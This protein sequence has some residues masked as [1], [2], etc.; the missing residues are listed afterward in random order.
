[1]RIKLIFV[2]LFFVYKVNCQILIYVDDS[3]EIE[4]YFENIFNVKKSNHI[5]LPYMVFKE[6][7]PDGDYFFFNMTR[8]NA[9]SKKNIMD[10]VIMDGH[11]K[12]NKREGRFNSYQTLK[13]NKII[14]NTYNYKDG[15]LEGYYY[16][17]NTQFKLSEGYYA[18]GKRNGFFIF[19]SMDT[20]K[21]KS[22][23]LFVDD[24]LIYQQKYVN[25][26][27]IPLEKY[28]E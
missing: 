4:K 5:D 9:R 19:H 22:I 2:F 25:N 15:I 6:N 7:L 8:K 16:C 20:G 11:Y 17:S 12:N 18:N 13:G 3:L 23:M 14:T 21:I 10:Y 24:S 28:S 27:M 26:E 1:M